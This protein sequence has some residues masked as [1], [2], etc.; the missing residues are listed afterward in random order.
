MHRFTKRI[1]VG[2]A[3]TWSDATR[4][5]DGDSARS[6]A[7][8]AW[9]SSN[10]HFHDIGIFGVIFRNE[11]D[12]D[13]KVDDHQRAVEFE[14]G[15]FLNAL[16]HLFERPEARASLVRQVDVGSSSDQR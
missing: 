3:E 13:E 7:E 15:G 14:L 11:T 9:P 4:G 10:Q 16:A 6:V 5:R 8:S 1:P 2:N 12:T